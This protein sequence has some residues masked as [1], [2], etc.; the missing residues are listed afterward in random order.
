M[1]GGMKKE[2]GMQI[3]RGEK[4]MKENEQKE[5]NGRRGT[6]GGEWKGGTEGGEWK[7]GNGRRGMEDGERKEGNGMMRRRKR[8]KKIKDDLKEPVQGVRE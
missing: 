3:W 5:G 6:E 2:R 1:R 7:E 8:G 4:W